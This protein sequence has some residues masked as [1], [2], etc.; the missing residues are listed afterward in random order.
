[1]PI[2][3]SRLSKTEQEK[4][5]GCLRKLRAK[6]CDV[7]IPS[8]WLDQSRGLDIIIR[9]DGSTEVVEGSPGVVVYAVSTRLVAR[10]PY[11]VVTDCACETEWDDG[12]VPCSFQ[13]QN[14]IYRIGR[15]QYPSAE[16]L[17]DKIEDGL[18]FTHP[19]QMVEGVILFVGI[20][21]IPD[22]YH[23]GMSASF[24]L[25]L[26]DQF[27]HEIEVESELFVSREMKRKVADAQSSSNLS[28]MVVEASSVRRSTLFDGEDGSIAT[29]DWALEALTADSSGRDG[30]NARTESPKGAVA[31][32]PQPGS[33]T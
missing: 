12:I 7:Q 16:V 29:P 1:M 8:E 28:E 2:T 4:Y 26:L 6:G 17:N 15:Q 22:N 31:G 5:L 11:V 3:K 30:W 27:E 10:K 21:P 33:S 9:R 23:L 18:Q 24:K 25:T 14:P 32:K 13:R 20:N 19:G